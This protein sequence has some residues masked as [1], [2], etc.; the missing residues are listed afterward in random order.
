M[1]VAGWQVSHVFVPLA[2]PLAMQALPMKQK[3]VLSVGAEQTPVDELHV[4]AVWHVSGVVQ[5]TW[6]P[7]V[8]TPA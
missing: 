4:P 2:A 3:P 8:Q 6:L 5:E 1:L 7:A